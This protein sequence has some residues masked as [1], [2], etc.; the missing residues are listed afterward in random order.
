MT[1]TDSRINTKV[2]KDLYVVSMI[3][4]AD[5]AAFFSVGTEPENLAYWKHH[6]IVLSGTAGEYS[7]YETGG[8]EI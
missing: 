7:Q 3:C 1:A 8:V 2:L 6:F 5:F 4:S